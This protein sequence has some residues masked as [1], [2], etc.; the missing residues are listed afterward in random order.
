MAAS[1]SLPTQ[2]NAP[3]EIL[4]KDVTAHTLGI[5]MIESDGHNLYFQP[6]IKNNSKFHVLGE[7]WDKH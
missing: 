4:V 1:I 7:N 3:V 5:D 6:L 2:D